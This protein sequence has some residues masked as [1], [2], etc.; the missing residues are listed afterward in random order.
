M[1]RSG[2]RR[3]AK[4]EMDAGISLEATDGSDTKLKITVTDLVDQYKEVDPKKLEVTIPVLPRDVV[5]GEIQEKMQIAR[6]MNTL[7]AAYEKDPNGT[8][9]CVRV[10][11]V[12]KVFAREDIAKGDL[13][14]VPLTTNFRVVVVDMNERVTHASAEIQKFTS[15]NSK[16]EMKVMAL[17]RLPMCPEEIA[18]KGDA[19]AVNFAV[20]YWCVAST[21]DSA[22]ANMKYERVSADGIDIP[23]LTNSCAIS[24]DAELLLYAEDCKVGAATS[25]SIKR[26]RVDGSSIGQAR[27][28]AKAKAK[29]KG[30]GSVG[31]GK[32]LPKRKP[33]RG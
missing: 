19:T 17:A 23:V 24:K 27:G 14:L 3:T 11:P 32:A 2:G 33:K 10:K 20:P 30:H 15:V 7:Q 13:K 28:K 12:K 31:R 1:P 5:H 22:K 29:A 6:A 8:K 9:V 18:A 26:K 16:Q 4:S 25:V 21:Q